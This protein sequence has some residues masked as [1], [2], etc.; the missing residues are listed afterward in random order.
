MNKK[1]HIH[2]DPYRLS[3]DFIGSAVV[4]KQTW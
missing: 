3:E 1:G 4:K 2:V